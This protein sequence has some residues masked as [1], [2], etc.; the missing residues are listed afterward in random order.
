MCAFRNNAS[1][2]FATSFF[3]VE[4]LATI[5]LSAGCETSGPPP[6]PATSVEVAAATAEQAAQFPRGVV[7]VTEGVF[8][9]VGYGLANSVL[10]VGDGGVV[11]VDTMESIEA[12]TPVR[13]AFREISADP[14]AAMIYT[15]N[16]GDHI[17]GAGLLA[18]NSHPEVIAHDSFLGEL[19][20]L[21]TATRAVSYRRSMRQFGTMLSQAQRIH[22]G[23]GPR[24]LNDATTTVAP[25]LP[26]KTFKGDRM[27][28]EIAGIRMELLHLPGESPDQIGVW[29]PDKRVLLAGDNYYHAFP[30]LYAIRGTPSRSTLEWTKSLDRMRKLRAEYLVPGHTLPVEGED[31]IYARLTDYRD[32]IQFTHDQTLRGMNMGLGPDEIA[33]TLRLPKSLASKPWLAQHYGRLDWSVRA[34]FDGYLGWFDGDAANLSPLPKKERA[35]HLAQLAGGPDKLR[36]AAEAALAAGEARWAVELADHLLLLEQFPEEAGRVRAAGLRM[37]AAVEPSAN[38]RNYY[39]T[40][41]LEAEGRLTVAP[42]DASRFPR[43]VLETISI[44]DFLQAMSRRLDPTKAE[45]KLLKVGF[46]FPDVGEEW[47]MQLRNS[48]IELRPELPDGADMTVTTSSLVWKEVLTSQRNATVAF[49]SGDLQVDRNRLELVRFLFLFR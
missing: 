16:H 39:T 2:C 24:L 12:A 6:E 25:L 34:V 45:G 13:E 18:A 36:D 22:C 40:Q 4:V 1:S 8:V 49:A 44:G 46:R 29:L 27:E 10:L 11:V 48:V 23:I 7:K 31:E 38:G 43:A 42:L 9:A 32:A 17:L 47:G 15:H 41:A 14:V 28:L 3:V 37:L 5:S 21:V 30:N 33:E 20:R 26:T 35:A 19:D